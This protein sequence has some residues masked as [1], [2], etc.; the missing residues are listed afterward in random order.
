MR[1][2]EML[3]HFGIEANHKPTTMSQV[4]PPARDML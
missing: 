1:S 2:R 3:W 4:I